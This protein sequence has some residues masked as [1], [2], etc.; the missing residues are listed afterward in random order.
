MI[1]DVHLGS[2]S[3]FFTHHWSQIQGSKKHRNPDP[4]PHTVSNGQNN[5]CGGGNCVL[6]RTWPA[7]TWWRRRRLSPPSQPAP[8]LHM[9][10]H[11]HTLFYWI[12]HRKVR[13]VIN[14]FIHKFTITFVCK[15]VHS[16]FVSFISNFFSLFASS[17]FRSFV[18]LVQIRLVVRSLAHLSVYPSII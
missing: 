16:L 2:G 9:F 11:F 7:A 8:F 12:D 15:F 10:N 4:D 13:Y 3:W 18:S 17:F 5:L 1:R 14:K 6:C